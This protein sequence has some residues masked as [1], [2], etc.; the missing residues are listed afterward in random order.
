MAKLRLQVEGCEPE[1]L[2]V[3]RDGG[4]RFVIS[5]DGGEPVQV[6]VV[7]GAN[8]LD[9]LRI[10]DTVVAYSASINGDEV[11]VWIRGQTYRFTKVNRDRRA[12]HA[13][14]GD[15]GELVAPMPGVVRTILA[16]DGDSI[17]RDQPLVVMESMKMEMTL[18]APGDAVVA[19]VACAE[20]EMVQMNQP[21]VHFEARE[22]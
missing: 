22:A 8:G 2:E 3:E 5:R 13:V 17:K 20:G 14:A 18:V 1:A 9:Y 4:G 19:M 21:L 10:G 15:A 16:K 12:G 6:R 7:D 11:S